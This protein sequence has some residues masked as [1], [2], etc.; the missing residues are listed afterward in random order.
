[1]RTLVTFLLT[2]A[3]LA[4]TL[5]AQSPFDPALEARLQSTLEAELASLGTPGVTAAIVSP[6][7]GAWRGAAGLSDPVSGERV[8]SGMLFGIG[9][10][11][12]TFTAAAILQLVESGEIALTDRVDK[13]L[14]EIP[15]VNGSVTI[16]HLLSHASGIYNYTASPGFWEYTFADLGRYITPSDILPFIGPANF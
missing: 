5:H 12:K 9:S 4:T 7:G 14:G 10:I 1:M 6:R 13:W 8:H 15:N 16:R 11:S 2:L 3:S